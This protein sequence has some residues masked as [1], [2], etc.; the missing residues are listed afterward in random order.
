MCN[1]LTRPEFWDCY[2]PLGLAE[3]FTAE[4]LWS[5]AQAFA[6]QWARYCQT[7][8]YT[9][10]EVARFFESKKPINSYGEAAFECAQIIVQA[11]S[12][13]IRRINGGLLCSEH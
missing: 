13:H 8:G 11:H 12:R 4:D 5:K 1:V 9:A 6:I 10:P 3:N 2:N 7:C